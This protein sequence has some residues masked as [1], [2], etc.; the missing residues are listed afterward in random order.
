[1]KDL[2]DNIIIRFFER[3]N[4]PEE[5][6]ELENWLLEDQENKD[7]FRTLNDSYHLSKTYKLGKGIDL[8]RA[9]GKMSN[10]ISFRANPAKWPT[11]RRLTIWKIAA[12]IAILVSIGLSAVM[13]TGQYLKVSGGQAVEFISPGGE[14]S[15]VLLADGTEVWL[16][17]DSRIIYDIKNPRMVKLNG[18]AFFDVAKDLKSP[19]IVQTGSKLQIRVHGTRF[20]VSAYDDDEILETTLERG[21]ISIEGFNSIPPV[22]LKPGQQLTYNKTT[23]KGKLQNVDPLLFSIWKENKLRFDNTPFE[24]V[25]KKI[26]RWYDVKISLDPG[27]G[28]KERFT[29]TVKTE[30][31]RELLEMISLTVNMKY[32]IDG[33]KVTISRK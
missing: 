22:F 1:M 27:L 13:M 23:G 21:S 29:M 26:E 11:L 25:V 33:E 17:S 28:Q 12:T 16:N 18:E 32:E 7:K 30:S 14:K 19:F 6:A 24:E 15:K 20:N 9:W 8:E 4:T 5:L 10:R 3:R 31:L 2:I